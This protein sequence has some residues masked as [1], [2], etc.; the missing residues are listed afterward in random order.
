MSLRISVRRHNSSSRTPHGDFAPEGN[1]P[2]QVAIG[3]LFGRPRCSG[4]LI[5]R[6]AVL[7][8]AHCLFNRD[9]SKPEMY[10]VFA[11]SVD[12]MNY[13]DCG[14]R[15]LQWRLIEKEEYERYGL[16][17][18]IKDWHVNRNQDGNST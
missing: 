13:D 4:T 8:S 14:F 12:L 18:T 10:Y 2:Y 9:K 5:S 11:G 16:V 3:F 6:N 1:A 15:G 17:N 7:T